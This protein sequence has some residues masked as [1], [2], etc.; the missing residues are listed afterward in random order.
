[1]RTSHDS[2]SRL[3]LSSWSTVTNEACPF[4]VTNQIGSQH[5]LFVVVF[6]FWDNW[7]WQVS[8]SFFYCHVHTTVGKLIFGAMFHRFMLVYKPLKPSDWPNLWQCQVVYR[9]THQK[10]HYFYICFATLDNVEVF[11]QWLLWK[12]RIVS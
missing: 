1:M 2:F 4:F 10:L 7:I 12:G 6:Y 5:L 9:Y 8:D 3:S 11:D